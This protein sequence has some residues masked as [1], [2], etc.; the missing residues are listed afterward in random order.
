MTTKIPWE[1]I[2]FNNN[3]QEFSLKVSEK[4]H[5]NENY[6]KILAK[7]KNGFPKFKESF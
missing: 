1:F 3:L 6:L 5:L 7:N 4:F 2:I